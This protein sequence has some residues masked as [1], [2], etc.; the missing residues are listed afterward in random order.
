MKIELA[1]SHE[2]KGKSLN[3]SSNPSLAR[4]HH[5]QEGTV[6]SRAEGEAFALGAELV[7]GEVLIGC[8]VPPHLQS[9]PKKEKLLS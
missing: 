8:R 1:K 7:V 5:V 2:R 9:R 4:A 3:R 6:K